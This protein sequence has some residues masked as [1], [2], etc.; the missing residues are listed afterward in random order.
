SDFTITNKNDDYVRIVA[1]L[2][3]RTLSQS[4]ISAVLGDNSGSD[5]K[6]DI[7][8]VSGNED[9][10]ALHF[11]D[12]DVSYV[13]LPLL[14]G[15]VFSADKNFYSCNV[16]KAGLQGKIISSVYLDRTTA[17]YDAFSSSDKSYCNYYYGD[18]VQTAIKNIRDGVQNILDGSSALADPVNLLQANNKYA[19]IKN[20]PRVY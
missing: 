7:L 17:L 20:C 19:V 3:Q 5:K 10:G 11:S 2:D 18:D 12:G 15:G 1:F 9:S 13:G 16:K 14:L 4:S 6:W 8:Y